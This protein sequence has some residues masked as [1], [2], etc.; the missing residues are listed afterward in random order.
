ML[1][2]QNKFGT[3]EGRKLIQGNPGLSVNATAQ[4]LSIPRWIENNI[5]SSRLT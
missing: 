1:W 4:E 2:Y 5:D 3:T